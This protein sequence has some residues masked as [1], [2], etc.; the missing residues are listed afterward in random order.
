LARERPSRVTMV[1]SLAG[2]RTPTWNARSRGI[3]DGIDLATDGTD[4]LLAAMEGN[5]RALAQDVATVRDA[6]FDI[7]RIVST[8]GGA[9][10]RA[11]LQIKADVLGVPVLRPVSGHGAAQGAAVLAGLAIGRI[12]GFAQVR[13]LSPRIQARFVPDPERT[14][15]YRATADRYAR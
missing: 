6:G 10:S 9:S 12:G 11:W 5:A 7:D 1:T 3:I 2:E 4:L 8:G 14:A 13:E 15:A